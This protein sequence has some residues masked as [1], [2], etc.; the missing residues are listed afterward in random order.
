[1]K[2]RGFLQK[3]AV[4][5]ASVVALTRSSS[6]ANSHQPAEK[7]FKVNFA[8]HDG[9]F[10]NH[11]GKNFIDQIKFMHDQ[12]FRAIE[13]NG[14]LGRPVEEQEKIGAELARLGMTM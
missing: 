11:G 7:T 5:G 1:M 10:G 14:M 4:A 13:D 9:M 8:P 12:G 2:R 6:K 3:T